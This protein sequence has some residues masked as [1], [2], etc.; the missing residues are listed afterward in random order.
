MKTLHGVESMRT[1]LCWLAGLF[2]IFAGINHFLKPEFY[3][4]IVPPGFPSPRFLVTASGIA[5][6][7]GG[8]GLLIRPLR[9]VA[10][11]GLIAMLIAVF[12]ANVFMGLHPEHF[13]MSPWSLWARLPMQL[14]FVAWVWWTA[15]SRSHGKRRTSEARQ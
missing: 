4:R 14:L 15:L 5:E 10:G 8:L 12:P 1:V 2:F 3:E 13:G 11:W 6:I 7:A 9:R